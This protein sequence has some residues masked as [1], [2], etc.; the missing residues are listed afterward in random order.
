MF[1]IRSAR[2]ARIAAAAAA[3]ALVVTGASLALA[4]SDALATTNPATGA[5][6]TT[7]ATDKADGDKIVAKDGVI[8]DVVTY[9][10]LHVGTIYVLQTQLFDKTTGELVDWMAAKVFQPSE[11]GGTVTVEIPVPAD[12]EGHE[13]VVYQTIWAGADALVGKHL[14]EI[15]IRPGA[16]PVVAE[17][18]PSNPDQTIKVTPP[19]P[20]SITVVTQECWGL[21]GT[22]V[23]NLID[24]NTGNAIESTQ[25]LNL[26]VQNIPTGRYWIAFSN[27]TI[28]LQNAPRYVLPS[29]TVW[30]VYDRSAY[31]LWNH[32]GT[33]EFDYTAG[34][35]VTFTL[36]CGYM[37]FSP[38]ALDL[39]GN[40]R[41]DTS[42][43][44]AQP[45]GAAFDL[46]G[47]G[48]PV[49]SGWLAQGD[50]FL[51]RPN[52]DGSVTS[53]KNLFGGSLGEGYAQ[54]R[55]LDANRDG[56]LSGTE[57]SGL[58]VWVDSNGD[59]R[60]QAKEIKGLDMYGITSIGTQHAVK[61]VADH[62][63]VV[64]EHG[65]ATKSNGLNVVV[66]DAYFR[67]GVVTGDNFTAA[68]AA[69]GVSQDRLAALP[70]AEQSAI[71]QAYATAARQ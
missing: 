34:T 40:G 49:P 28:P 5:S 69:R 42:S 60:A 19:P 12:R 26:S 16:T 18:N 30:S 35:D 11:S 25:G 3:A 33:V 43:V 39:S 66:G 6:V 68:A 14:D 24:V 8:K 4:Q 29:D 31:A 41:I 70:A 59:H 50:G 21:T 71:A 47:T 45:E 64:I 13:L 10:G 57:L 55:T 62:G 7:V 38:V 15:E 46:L 56:A 67:L 23:T 9:D 37:D 2:L 20:G 53:L 17:N 65:S 27:D 1:G 61:P 44:S 36:V 51:V 48:S 22:Y 54:L 63:N 52:A 32:G 58:K